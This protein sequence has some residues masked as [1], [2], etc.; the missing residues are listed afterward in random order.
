M[1][2]RSSLV[3]AWSTMAA[4]RGVRRLLARTT[5]MK[6]RAGGRTQAARARRPSPSCRCGVWTAAGEG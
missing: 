2:W 5:L 4:T 1:T 3:T 6:T